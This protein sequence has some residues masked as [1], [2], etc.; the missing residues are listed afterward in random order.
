MW[1]M[2]ETEGFWRGEI[3][4][5]RKN[6]EIYPEWLTITAV[7]DPDGNVTHYVGSFSDITQRIEDETKIRSL[8]F[9]DPLT[10]LPNRRLLMDRLQQAVAASARTNRKGALLFVDLDNFKMLND[11][12]GHEKGD[13]LLQEIARRLAG[14]VREADTVG[15][16]GGDEFVVMLDDLSEVPEEAAAQAKTV[17][18]K[19]L[20]MV[21]QPFL[22]AGHECLITASIGITLFGDHREDVGG[23]LKQADIAMYQAKAAGGDTARFFAPALQA[24]INARASLE[25]ELRTAIHQGQFLLYYQPQVDR[26]TVI[27]AEALVRWKHPRR[28][29]LAPAEFITLSEETGLII[30][31]GDWVLETACRQLVA[32]ADREETARLTI[33]VNISARQLRQPEFVDKVLAALERTGANPS[34]LELELTESMLVENI[35]EVIEKMTELKLRGLK[36]SLDDFGTGYSSLSYLRRLPLDRLKIDRAF[37]RDLLEDTCGGAIAQAIVSLSCAMGLPVLA[38]GVESEEQRVF[39]AEL[40]CHLYQGYLFSRPVPMDEF[41]ALFAHFADDLASIPL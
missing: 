19:I 24:A 26:G 20:A 34:N 8:A 16:L 41:E 6:G 1:R 12:L 28:S 32:W 23:L 9:Y 22:L 3:W 40:G 10:L 14:C 38:E 35:E 11:T 18:K 15:R 5:R 36:F 33:A 13:L 39:L 27:G 7:L 29:I 4:N 17:G 25:E 31:L 37:V 30:P 21:G 2:I